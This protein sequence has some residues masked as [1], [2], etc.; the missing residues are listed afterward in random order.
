MSDRF[1]GE[2]MFNLRQIV[3]LPLVCGGSVAASVRFA[4]NQATQP[5]V[6]TLP[7]VNM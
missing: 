5:D 1:D 3:S 4:L 6:D 7:L 2:L